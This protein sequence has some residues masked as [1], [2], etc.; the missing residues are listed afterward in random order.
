MSYCDLYS[1]GF[2]ERN[3]DHFAAIVRVALSDGPIN[4]REQAFLD[5]LAYNL[6][7]DEEHYIKILDD[8]YGYPVHT[9][10]FHDIRLERLYDIARMIYADEIEGADE[11]R[12]MRRQCIGLG[13][14][15]EN[16]DDLITRSME[17]VHNKVDLDTFQEALKHQHHH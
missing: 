14:R 13:F 7:I 17:L 4:E 6:D 1:S 2:R 9:P 10:H 16:I 11:F 8:P 3:R 5:R 12:I 15:H